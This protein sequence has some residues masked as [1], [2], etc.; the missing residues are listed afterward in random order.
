M[1]VY[2]ALFESVAALK[3][4]ELRGS[5]VPALVFADPRDRLISTVGLVKVMARG[6]LNSWKLVTVKSRLCKSHLVIDPEAVG[7]TQWARITDEIEGFVAAATSM[8]ESAI[9]ARC[10]QAG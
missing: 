2:N 1:A 8:P 6:K 9:L 3:R 7:P 10:R 4:S 5:R